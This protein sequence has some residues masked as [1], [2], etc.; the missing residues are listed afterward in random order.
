MSCTLLC[1]F[2]NNEMFSSPNEIDLVSVY[3]DVV[4]SSFDMLKLGCFF[5]SFIQKLYT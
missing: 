2:D 4:G 1:F 5:W 3:F